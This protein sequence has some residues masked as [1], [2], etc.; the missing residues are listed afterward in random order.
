MSKQ[1]HKPTNNTSQWCDDWAKVNAAQR[2][3]AIPGVAVV[4]IGDGPVVWL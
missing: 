2:L 3:S 4:S 1:K